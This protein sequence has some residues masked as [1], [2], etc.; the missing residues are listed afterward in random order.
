MSGRTDTVGD[1]VA[2][3]G[4]I[5]IFSAGDLSYCR[6]EGSFRLCASIF[7]RSSPD[8]VAAELELS[9]T[10]GAIDFGRYIRLSDE[11]VVQMVQWLREDVQSGGLGGRLYTDSLTRMLTVHLL[12]R[13]G[14]ASG[15]R[16]AQP[17]RIDRHQL[18]RTLQYIHAY[19]DRNLPGGDCRRLSCE[20]LPS[21]EAVQGRY[22]ADSSPVC[23]SGKNPQGAKAADRR[24]AG[25]RDRCHTRVQ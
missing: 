25:S 8:Q 10:G 9:I 12:H 21:G 6:W 13:Y 16:R 4:D 24:D 2:K 1:G 14:T 3:P 7:P 23:D 15:H 19:L 11:R 22:G 17:Q 18:D 20:P 5:N